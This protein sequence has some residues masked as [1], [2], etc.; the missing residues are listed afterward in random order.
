MYAVMIEV[1]ACH[2]HII[3]YYRVILL[4]GTIVRMHVLVDT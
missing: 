2:Y 1:A 4:Y 3:L